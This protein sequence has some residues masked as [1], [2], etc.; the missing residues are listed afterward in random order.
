MHLVIGDLT[1]PVSGLD[2]AGI[3][4]SLPVRMLKRKLLNCRP[5]ADCVL[6]IPINDPF[7]SSMVNLS[8]VV[9]GRTI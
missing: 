4:V 7:N 1:N 8:E 3:E 2:F 5:L 9:L 6:D